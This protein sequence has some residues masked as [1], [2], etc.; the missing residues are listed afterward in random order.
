MLNLGYQKHGWISL[1]PSQRD[2]VLGEK[3]RSKLVTGT[4]TPPHS[5]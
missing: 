5:T 3:P 2:L 1:K 4:L